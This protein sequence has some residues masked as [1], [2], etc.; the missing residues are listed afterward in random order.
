[1]SIQEMLNPA[2]KS[3]ICDHILRSLPDWFG[4]E[5]SI[6]EYTRDVRQ[7]R[8][9]AAWEDG[10]PVGFIALKDHNAYTAEVAVMGILQAYH[11]LGIGRQLMQRCEAHCKE[12]GKEFLTV[13]TLDS[14]REDASYAKTRLFYLSLGFRPLEV[15][16]LLW[17]ESNPCLLMA[18]YIGEQMHGEVFP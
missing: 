6:V 7:M 18:K 1:M 17:D 4:V 13:K 9:W 11:R 3:M 10:K 16:P 5:A 12:N 8:L 15:F 2:E 14:S